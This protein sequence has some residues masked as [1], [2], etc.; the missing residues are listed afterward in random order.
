MRCPVLYQWEIF[1]DGELPPD[2]KMQMEAHLRDCPSCS[3]LVAGLREETELF[4]LSLASTPVPPDLAMAISKRL[5]DAG[6]SQWL[7]GFFLAV[8]V[9][10]GMLGALSEGW[11][12]LFE[13]LRNIIQLFVGSDFALQLALFFYDLVLKLSGAAMTGN[14]VLP[15]LVVLAVCVL[16][17]QLKL[18]RGGRTYV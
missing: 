13:K 3:R 1:V 11:W 18:Q 5:A 14:P 15:A 10:T 6:G 7:I 17:A 4:S 12:P 2:R 9:F 16:W 8:L